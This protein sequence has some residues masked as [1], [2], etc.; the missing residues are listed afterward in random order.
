M[1]LF[2]NRPHEDKVRTIVQ[3]H[4]QPTM[5]AHCTTRIARYHCVNFSADLWAVAARGLAQTLTAADFGTSPTP[6]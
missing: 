2:D 3:D 6:R 4:Y 1:Y 5:H